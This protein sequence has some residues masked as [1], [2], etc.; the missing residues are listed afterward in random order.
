MA[1][2]E[3]VEEGGATLNQQLYRMGQDSPPSPATGPVLPGE[4]GTRSGGGQQIAGTRA[5]PNGKAPG[6]ASRYAVGFLE[7]NQGAA[8][9]ASQM[10]N[11]APT[12]A[13]PGAAEQYADFGDG[14]IQRLY[15]SM[16]GKLSPEQQ[17]EL[18]GLAAQ[19]ADQREQ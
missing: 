9:L 13:G 2:R 5:A 12:S 18:D 7:R 15:Q 19:L 14:D 10:M 3:W 4:G 8:D 17:A 1:T 16:R 11:P 6:R